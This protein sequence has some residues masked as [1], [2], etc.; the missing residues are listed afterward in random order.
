MFAITNTN[1]A[2]MRFFKDCLLIR[3]IKDFLSGQSDINGPEANWVHYDVMRSYPQI[4]LT[5]FLSP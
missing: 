4:S 5:I 1:L 2:G 3:V